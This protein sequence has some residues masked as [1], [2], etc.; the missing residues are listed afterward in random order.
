MPDR[1]SITP[2]SVFPHTRIHLVIREENDANASV[3]WINDYD[4]TRTL[5]R[6]YPQTLDMQREWAS[7]RPQS[8]TDFVFGIWLPEEQKLI[9]TTGWH[10]VDARNHTAVFGLNIGDKTEWRKGYG[11]ETVVQMLH[12]AFWRQNLRK[13]TLD[14]LGNNPGARALYERCGFRPIGILREH[15]FRDG[16][17][18]DRTIMEL[19]REEWDPIFAAYR[20]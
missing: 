2:Q 14:V 17:Y 3:H 15:E 10:H 19:F 1:I 6:D 5:G 20:K 18:V 12:Y 8:N 9:G 16:R 4:V 7:G 13:V 11:T